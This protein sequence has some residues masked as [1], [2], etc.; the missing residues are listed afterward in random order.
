MHLSLKVGKEMDI[1]GVV[2]LV[3]HAMVDLNFVKTAS[4]K[5]LCFI[6]WP[7]LFNY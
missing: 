1:D 5:V 6:I 4:W 2:A 7:M 3:I